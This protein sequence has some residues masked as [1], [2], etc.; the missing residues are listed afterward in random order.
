MEKEEDPEGHGAV[1]PSDVRGMRADHPLHVRKSYIN[2]V[3]LSGRAYNSGIA[4]L[5]ADGCAG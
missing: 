2:I 3:L 1:S 5:G 4:E